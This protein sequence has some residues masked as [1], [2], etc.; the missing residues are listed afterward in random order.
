MFSCHSLNKSDKICENIKNFYNLIKKYE[1]NYLVL[2]LF[3]NNL[4]KYP[5]PLLS[6]FYDILKHNKFIYKKN[7]IIKYKNNKL[8]LS[9]QNSYVQDH[10]T[11]KLNSFKIDNIN[12]YNEKALDIIKI[13]PNMFFDHSTKF[14]IDLIKED[15]PKP[16]ESYDILYHVVSQHIMGKKIY[17]Y[18]ISRFTYNSLVINQ[19]KNIQNYDINKYERIQ[20]K[21]KYDVMEKKNIYCYYYMDP[22]KSKLLLQSAHFDF[23]DD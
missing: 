5:L 10:I 23:D 9:F 4:S 1:Y 14:K 12:L 6:I 17:R 7:Y 15:Q 22:L 11:I 19:I 13:N 3:N 16:Y 20:I 18:D 2:T 21:N 8:S